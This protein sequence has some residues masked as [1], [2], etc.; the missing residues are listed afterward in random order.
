MSKVSSWIYQGITGSI[1]PKNLLICA[2]VNYGEKF[3]RV[4]REHM[5][6]AQKPEGSRAFDSKVFL[7]P[8]PKS[9]FSIGLNTN[10]GRT[11][12]ERLFFELD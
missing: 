1:F 5:C 6:P 8:K 9:Y 2:G 10:F 3:A 7:F 12:N 4:V 11:D